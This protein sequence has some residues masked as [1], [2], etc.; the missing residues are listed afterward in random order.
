MLT[1]NNLENWTKRNTNMKVEVKSNG[2][3]GKVW[4]NTC[5]WS[6]SAEWFQWTVVSWSQKLMSNQRPIRAQ[7]HA[8]E[9]GGVRTKAWSCPVASQGPLVIAPYTSQASYSGKPEWRARL[10]GRSWWSRWNELAEK[11]TGGAG[12]RPTTL[13]AGGFSP[14][15]HGAQ[16]LVTE[17]SQSSQHRAGENWNTNRGVVVSACEPSTW[18]SAGGVWALDSLGCTERFCLRR[19]NKIKQTNKEK[20]L[21][22]P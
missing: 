20:K 19:K 7:K 15:K 18:E 9:V 12:S 13:A 3:I 16:E 22:S 4:I 14:Q 6:V 10:F 21:N 5:D 2:K 11:V 8:G 1:E 17:T